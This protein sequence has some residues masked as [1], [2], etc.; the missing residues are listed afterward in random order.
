MCSVGVPPGTGLGN[1]GIYNVVLIKT[2]SSIFFLKEN[3][4]YKNGH[5]TTF[6]NV[7]DISQTFWNKQNYLQCY[8]STYIYDVFKYC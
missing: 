8:D 3:T 1:T 2:K 4:R 5:F 7:T 6:L